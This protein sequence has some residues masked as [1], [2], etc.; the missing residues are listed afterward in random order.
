MI[1]NN[2]INFKK[3]WIYIYSREAKDIDF[4]A[5]CN[6]VSAMVLAFEI[7]LIQ[8]NINVQ[9]WKGVTS[10]RARLH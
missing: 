3:D 9:F 5:T 1:L 7:T 8:I 2:H 10:R 4:G 6:S